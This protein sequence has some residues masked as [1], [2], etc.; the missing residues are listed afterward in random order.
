MQVDDGLHGSHQGILP[1]LDGIDKSLSCIHFLFQEHHGLFGFLGLV[2]L[3]LGVFLYHFG[4]IAAHAQFGNIPVVE[5]Q[6]DSAVVIGIHN[7]IGYD[8]LQVLADSFTQRRSRT[9]V[10]F[11][12][13]FYGLLE[14]FFFQSEFLLYFVPMLTGEI[15]VAFGNDCF[16]NIKN[17]IGSE[18]LLF[19][20][21]PY[22]DEKAFLQVAGSQSGRVEI[23]NDSQCF[24]QFSG[25]GFDAGINGKLIA[26][27]VQ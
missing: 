20:L 7:K 22:L 14:S 27:A 21:A 1:L 24:F 3:V 26:D 18:V 2:C 4:E 8:L 6:V 12:D 16:F 5:R 25:S 11:A 19:Y 13:F 17:R 10:Q 15:F 23:L 9:R